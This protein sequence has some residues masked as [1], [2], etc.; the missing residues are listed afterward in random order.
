MKAVRLY[1]KLLL[2]LKT[3]L[4]LPLDLEYQGLT[5][6]EW[7]HHYKFIAQRMLDYEKDYFDCDDFAWVMKAA[8]ARM[9]VN[10]IGLVIGITP[11]GLHAWNVI[12]TKEGSL[13]QLEPQTGATQRWWKGRWPIAVIM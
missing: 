1:F 2:T 7:K 3:P 6:A 12:L 10:G 9:R 8:F 13:W 11:K 4:I 5:L